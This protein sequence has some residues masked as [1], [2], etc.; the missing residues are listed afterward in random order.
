MSGTHS[1]STHACAVY[2]LTIK[3]EGLDKSDVITWFNE[4]AKK[5]CFQLEKGESTGYIHYQ[6]R[7]SL[8]VKVRLHTFLEKIPD[9]M[10]VRASITSSNAKAVDF[11]VMKD[12]TRIEGPWKDTDPKPTSELLNNLP[13]WVAKVINP[14]LPKWEGWGEE[15]NKTLDKINFFPWQ[16]SVIDHSRIEPDNRTINVIVD[17]LGDRGKS[18]FVTLMVCLNLVID[19][20][21]SNEIKDIAR[22][23]MNQPKK[24]CYFVDLP[25]ATDKNHI[26]NFMASIEQLKNGRAYDDRYR[27]QSAVFDAPH[28]WIFTNTVPPTELLTRNR[29]KIWGINHQLELVPW[30][31]LHHHIE[32]H[33][34]PEVKLTLNIV[35]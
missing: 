35:R 22:M 1:T 21:F 17:L 25:K 20:A 29:W 3:S 12:E 19:I 30:E 27:F 13:R 34:I 7:I 10:K 31:L 16:K 2:D 15:A 5:W 33:P 32:L 11:Y 23:I 8:K 14:D 26:H 6:C 24:H 9:N 18:W 4:I 28:V